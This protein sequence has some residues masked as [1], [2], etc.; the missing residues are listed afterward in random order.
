MFDDKTILVQNLVY[1]LSE[2]L[3]NR[4]NLC[5]SQQVAAVRGCLAWLERVEA[6]ES[7]KLARMDALVDYLKGN[8]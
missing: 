2:S 8:G 3:Y 1:D 5:R 6:E 4:L 7:A